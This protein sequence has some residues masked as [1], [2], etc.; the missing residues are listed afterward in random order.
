MQNKQVSNGEKEKCHPVK[1]HSGMGHGLMMILCCLVPLGVAFALKAM[2]YGA[3]AG[4]LVIL[5]CP[6]MHIFMMR[7]M[8]KGKAGDHAKEAA[9]SEKNSAKDGNMS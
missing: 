6:L 2:G 1:G 8:L 5:L 9:V 3:A 7:G 4:Y